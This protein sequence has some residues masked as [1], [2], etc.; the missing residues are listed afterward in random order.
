MHRWFNRLRTTCVFCLSFYY[1]EV[2][3]SVTVKSISWIPN[4]HHNK[5]NHFSIAPD[6][7]LFLFPSFFFY[8]SFKG[9]DGL[10]VYPTLDNRILS[11]P[12][13]SSLI[14]FHTIW[15]PWPHTYRDITGPNHSPSLSNMNN[16]HPTPAQIC[17]MVVC[18][19]H[20]TAP[21]LGSS[22]CRKQKHKLDT[23]KLL[24]TITEHWKLLQP[25]KIED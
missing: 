12:W 15:R 24:D 20:L 4:L 21:L 13:C 25:C 2:E 17:T 6:P 16:T 5:I 7:I 22:S 3:W 8:F 18:F 9:L 14:L 19:V 23:L 10:L 1:T 11:P